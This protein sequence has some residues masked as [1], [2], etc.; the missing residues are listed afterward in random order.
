MCFIGSIAG[1]Q[2]LKAPA[3]YAVAKA[4]LDT[5]VKCLAQDLAADGIRVN[6]VHPGN[7]YFEGGR[8]AELQKER[9]EATE[10][11]IASQ[12]AQQRFGTPEEIANVVA[13]LTSS[14]AS[15]MTGASVVVDGGQLKTL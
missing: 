11:Y 4:A 1:L 10:E 12:V 3:G 6:I 15:F 9:K 14:K 2:H 7:I 5:Y 13:F 8:W